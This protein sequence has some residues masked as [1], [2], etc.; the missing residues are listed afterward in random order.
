[1]IVPPESLDVLVK[2]I[3]KLLVSE[4]LYKIF[5]TNMRRIIN[6][7]DDWYCIATKIKKLYE[8]IIAR[9]ERKIY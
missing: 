9:K 1:L 6:K 7:K 2:E 5:V 3:I 8:R 4:K